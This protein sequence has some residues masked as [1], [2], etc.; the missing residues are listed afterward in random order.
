MAWNDP[1]IGIV[2]PGV[3][4]EYKGIASGKGYYLDGVNLNLSD[5]D[6]NWLGIRDMFKF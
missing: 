6:Q 2:W 4:G 3:T 5:K 1:E